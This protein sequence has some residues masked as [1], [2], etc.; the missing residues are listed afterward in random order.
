MTESLFSPSWYRVASL[1][2]R[3][4]GHTRIHRHHYRNELWYVLQDHS[5]GKFHRFTP[6]AYYLIGLMDGERTVQ[7]LWELAGVQLGDDL[8]TQDE[9]IR[10]LGQLHAADVLQCDVPPDLLE[11]FRRH[12]QHR[13]TRWKQRLRSPLVIRVPLWDPERFLSRWLPLVRPLFSWYGVL[14]WLAVVLTALVLAGIHWSELTESVVDRVLAPQNLLLLWLVY[15]L[16][17]ALHEL[18]HGFAT[19]VWGGEVHEIGIMFLVFMPVPYVDASAAS[20]F[21]DRRKR[22]LVGAAGIIVELFLASVALFVWLNVEPGVVRAIAYN[23]MLIGGVS[24]VLFNGNPLLRFDGYYVLADAV[25]IPNL[26]MR[27]NRYFGYLFQRYLLALEKAESPVAAP[28]ERFWFVSYGIAAFVYRILI[29]AAIVLFIAGKFFVV[30]VLLA[31]WAVIPLLLVPTW[32]ALSFLLFS[33]RLH[34]RRA[35]AI[36]VSASLVCLLGAVLFLVPV[37]LRTQAEGVV[38]LPERSIVRAGTD[39]FV[40]ELQV[41]SGTLVSEGAPLIVTQDPFLTAELHVLESRHEE[42]SL[43]Y[44]LVRN[45]DRVRAGILKEDIRALEE[46]LASH[47]EQIERLV[48]RS[49]TTGRLVLPLAADLPGQYLHQGQL[50]G[51]V[52]DAGAPIARVVVAQQDVSLVRQQTRD[53][54]LRFAGSP[55]VVLPATIQREVPGASNRLPAV[56]LGSQGGGAIAIDPRDGQGVTTFE[57]VFQFDVSIAAQQVPD[58]VGG[59]VLVQFD[60]GFEPLGL[61]GY[62]AIR[63]LLLR[64]FNV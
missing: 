55:D 54:E 18:G 15:P 62:R 7:Q 14:L 41:E 39:G 60:H 64:R 12:Q 10:L 28:G 51:Y 25:E 5:A 19:R 21:R 4:R 49:P 16:V 40:Q 57:R 58:Y 37:P 45:E 13:Q 61:Q 9:V 52:L 26:G 1:R 20:A 6:A 34:R 32:K 30:G 22:M 44:N 46:D 53:V 63:Q 59:R 8:P 3:L 17:K 33:P 43:E 29:M 42:L 50:V 38:W 27:A 48:I 47:R 24:T 31:L 56:A 36:A 23:I 2:P 11:L 35:H